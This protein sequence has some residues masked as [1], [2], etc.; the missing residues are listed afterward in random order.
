MAGMSPL[1]MFFH[2]R[3]TVIYLVIPRIINAMA[4]DIPKMTGDDVRLLTDRIRNAVEATGCKGVVLG[5]SGGIDSAVVAKLCVDAI[6]AENVMCVF[7]PSRVT[8]HDDYKT[9]SDLCTQW[10]MEYRILDVQPAVDSLS[11]ILATSSDTPLDR[12]NIAARCRM[13]VLFNLAKKMGKVVMGASNESEIMIGY[14]TKFGDGACDISPLSGIYK[15]QVKQIARIIGVPGEIIKKP[16][17]AGLWI[18]QTDEEELGMTYDE[19]DP[20]LYHISLGRTDDQISSVTGIP[21]GKAVSVREWVI[22]S[23]HKRNPP[24]RP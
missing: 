19:L 7:M 5:L 1:Y 15:T 8:P 13:I 4:N 3:R 11:A 9:T 20:I 18:G 2:V 16:P 10:G 12:G 21:K 17:T 22:R 6:G 14:F 24:V 23:E